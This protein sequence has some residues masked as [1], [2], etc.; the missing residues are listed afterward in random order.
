MKVAELRS[1]SKAELETLTA[2]LYKELFN[3]RVQ[4]SLQQEVKTHKFGEARRT[5][6][7]IKMILGE[8]GE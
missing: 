5:I 7:C 1:K 4:R 8:K 2:D 6:A 3:L